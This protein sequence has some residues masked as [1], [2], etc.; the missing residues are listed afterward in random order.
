LGLSANVPVIR[1]H[2][3]AY[4]RIESTAVL[5]VAGL[6]GGLDEKHLAAWGLD[7]RCGPGDAVLIQIHQGIAGYVWH[8]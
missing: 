4:E 1:E 3:T 7:E 5:Q 2:A 6:G 8:R